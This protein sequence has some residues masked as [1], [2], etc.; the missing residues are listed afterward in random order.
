MN[1]HIFLSG[2]MS[3]AA[4]SSPALAEPAVPAPPRPSTGKITCDLKNH[5]DQMV[6]LEAVLSSSD[7]TSDGKARPKLSISGSGNRSLDGDYDGWENTSN[8]S[9]SFSYVNRLDHSL[10]TMTLFGF[11][12]SS[13]RAA[14]VAEVTP[15]AGGEHVLFAGLCSW[16]R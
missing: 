10:V 9:M 4:A 14:A 7:G 3:L 16:V 11:S 2:A 12:W 5:L 15:I 6:Q 1:A 13:R 8:A